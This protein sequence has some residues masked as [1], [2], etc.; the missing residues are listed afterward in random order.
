LD[1]KL[2]KNID[3]GILII[4]ILIFLFSILIISSATHATSSGNLHYM[5]SQVMWM[6]VGL[7]AMFIMVIIDYHSL[8]NWAYIIYALNIGALA[9]VIFLGNDRLGAQRWISIGPFGFQPSEFAKIAVIV[10]L[11]TILDKKRAVTGI[12]DLLSVLLH[13][14]V[15]MFL[16]MKQP[17]LGTSLVLLAVLMGLLFVSGIPQKIMA[18]IIAAGILSLPV[19]W[20]YLEDFQKK[21]LLTFINPNLDPLN[22]GYHVI[23]SK[24]AIGSGKLFGK[25]IFKGTQNQLDFLPEQHTDF[26]F[27]VLGEELG[28]IGGM[29]LFAL[30]FGLIYKTLIIAYKARN[31]L[32]T[33]MVT[34]VATMWTFQILVNIGMTLGIMP[35]TGIPLPFMSYGGSSLIMNMMAVGLVLNVGMRRQKILF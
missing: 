17:D 23:Q 9:L 8:A 22:S 7:I 34:G 25:G 21:R 2:L 30:L 31:P 12:K 4:V 26:I 32:G 19:L 6:C 16:I 35:I 20:N 27:A 33:Y 10:S 14:A 28:F 29:L 1:P 11:A 3:Y 5:K 15:P 13:V 18:G 24:I